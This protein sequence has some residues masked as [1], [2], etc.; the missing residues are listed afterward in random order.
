M[1]SIIDVSRVDPS[2][3]FYVSL[4]LRPHVEECIKSQRINPARAVRL[5]CLDE[6]LHGI[7]VCEVL[8]LDSCAAKSVYSELGEGEV[9]QK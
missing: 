4:N 8:T 3:T 2:W 5:A 1:K 9:S 6:L 7:T